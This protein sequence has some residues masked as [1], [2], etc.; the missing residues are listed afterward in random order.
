MTATPAVAG[1]ATL[2][3][4]TALA[5]VI[6]GGLW[7]VYLAV[8]I[9]VVVGVGVLLRSVRIP[10]LV[11]GL[12][13]L[14]ALLCLLVTIFTR[15]GILIVL[16]DPQSITDLGA[17]LGD[18]VSEV[19]TGIPPVPDTPAMRCLVMVAIGL[20]AVLVDT[21]AV[22]A[23]APAA[24]GL[25]LLCVF[26]VPASLADD[27]LP[28]WTFV[29]GAA[30]FALLLVVD[31][32]RRHD[33]WRGR[34]GGGS[35]GPTA[36]VV[37]VTAL[38]I[39]AVSGGALTLV[40]TVGRLPGGGDE[41]GGG[42]GGLGIDPMT[43]LRGMLDRG[44][45]RELFRVRG[46]PKSEYLRAMTLREYVPGKGWQL[47]GNLS[48]GVAANGVVSVQPGDPGTGD[49][50]SIEIEPVTWLDNWLPVYGRPR[51]FAGVDD[52]WRWDAGRG[53]VYSVRAR[54]SEKYTLE[55][56]LGEPGT[57]TLRGVTGNPDVDQAYLEAPSVDPEILELA[58][59]ITAGARNQFDK[60]YALHQYFT[61][62][63]QGFKYSLETKNDTS[64][65]ALT[66]FVLKGKTGYCEQYASAMAVMARAVGIPS[67]VALG[68]TAGF[69]TDEYQ[70]I[71]TQDAHAWVEVYFPDY[72]WM[73]FDPTPLSD[74]R[75]VVP[76]YIS[77]MNP[78]DEEDDS[79]TTS[80]TTTTT[81]T[82]ASAGTTTTAAPGA[83]DQ[84]GQ[85]Q[86][87]DPTPVWHMIIALVALLLAVALW[88]LVAFGG[89]RRAPRPPILVGALA[90]TVATAT[91]AVAFVTWWLTVPIVLAAVVAAPAALRVLKRRT[92]LHTVARLGPDAADAAW[93]ELLAE[94]VDRG[95]RVPS[96]ETVRIAARRLARTHQ[97]DDAGRNG[98]R[99]VVG[100]IERSWYSAT[101][102]ADPALP[103]ALDE[104]R[105][106][107]HRNA[108]LAFRARVLPRS[109]L[110][111]KA[112]AEEPERV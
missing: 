16:P 49:V 35:P 79:G 97:L 73:T 47:G 55:T 64:T 103:H 104:V 85:A 29:C 12:G 39:A 6:A 1:L 19:Q 8:T 61:D 112:P 20:V 96:T 5:S 34:R 102:G 54:K 57:D 22:G 71:T 88:L 36:T 78:D 72:G 4:S 110:H 92:R 9:A 45:T 86:K 67:R 23:A 14:V 80:T 62:G 24:S 59:R 52:N 83:A 17:V 95:T 30:G 37:T 66:D 21:L 65:D 15:S 13:Q 89:N 100:A 105:R 28:M 109:V 56:A 108:P 69:P 46:L 27:M 99:A 98:L 82:T 3:A 25:V 58:K 32:R 50:T 11:V 38:V 107:L 70:T 75:S 91:F 77:G 41:A 31:G 18:A 26:A 76:P 33:S 53:M 60:A 81:T 94:S 51:R 40:G 87:S 10:A 84:S 68:F 2:C 111:P 43:E 101:G 42:S 7:L 74:G 44:E 90:A 63:T 106:S 93:A 48:E